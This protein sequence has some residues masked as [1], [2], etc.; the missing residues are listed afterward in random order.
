MVLKTV[1]DFIRYCIE[2]GLLSKNSAKVKCKFNLTDTWQLC[3]KSS[4]PFH[5]DCLIGRGRRIAEMPHQRN[6]YGPVTS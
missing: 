4:E 5:N 6:D 2:S 1:A 3:G